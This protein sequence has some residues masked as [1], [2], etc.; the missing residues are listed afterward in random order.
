MA[1]DKTKVGDAV[2]ASI[3]RS[4]DLRE[5]ILLSRKQRVLAEVFDGT[6][7]FRLWDG[8]EVTSD[9]FVNLDRGDLR[10]I[11]SKHEN[12]W[13]D[14]LSYL[15]NGVFAEPVNCSQAMIQHNMI[16]DQ[17]LEMIVQ[18]LD[19]M[20]D[21]AKASGSATPQGDT[22]TGMLYGTNTG[23]TGGTSWTDNTAT[24]MTADGPPT[25]TIAAS[26]I[27]ESGFPTNSG[28]VL[29]LKSIFGAPGGSGVS[30]VATISQNV[31]TADAVTGATAGTHYT[32]NTA[33]SILYLTSKINLGAAD[34]L[35]V[36]VTWTLADT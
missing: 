19:L 28:A 7:L 6:P 27:Y 20:I 21:A 14:G 5:Q 29:T 32:A 13:S 34:T 8:R 16:V 25:S 15:A 36:T 4:R 9:Y 26:K 1:R 30:D 23:S 3:G 18:N 22:P 17:G 10:E 24:E 11:K 33:T 35:A 2:S 31:V 12:A